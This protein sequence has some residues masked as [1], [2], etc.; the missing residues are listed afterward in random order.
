MKKDDDVKFNIVEVNG[1]RK[2]EWNDVAGKGYY[3][4]PTYYYSWVKAMEAYFPH[5]KAVHFALEENNKLIAV[6][7]FVLNSTILELSSSLML[8]PGFVSGNI[9]PADLLKHIIKYCINNRIKKISF[10]IP[11]NYYYSEMLSSYGFNVARKVT[12]FHLNLTHHNDFVSYVHSLE[13]KGKKSDIKASLKKGMIVE[14]GPFEE[15][16]YNRF[17]KFYIE[18]GCRNAV[19][20]PTKKFYLQLANELSVKGCYWI[21]VADGIDVGSALTFETGDRIWIMWL[22]GGEAFK[23]LKVS[24]FLYVQ[25]IRYA[26]LNNFHMVNFGTSSIDSPLGDFKKRLGAKPFFHDIFELELGYVTAFKKLFRDI[27]RT[28]RIRNGF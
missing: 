6:A 14:S 13:N 25:I 9:N 22:Q 16:L 17:D 5:T 11:S 23:S 15:C 10:Q 24:T 21:A 18:M 20:L 27:T 7:P 8:G 28:F 1:E 19:D 3:P 2:L 12:F 26:I 4:F